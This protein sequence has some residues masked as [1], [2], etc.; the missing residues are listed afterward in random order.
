MA[1]RTFEMSGP[2]SLWSFEPPPGS[3]YRFP[4]EQGNFP[5]ESV[6]RTL[7]PSILG[8]SVLGL[9]FRDG[10]VIAADTLGSYGTLARY[11]NCERLFK[12]NDS[13]VI[14][15]SGDFADFQY[16]KGLLEQQV[17][18]EECLNDGFGFTPQS[19]HCLLTRLMYSRRDQFNPLWNTIIVAGLEDDKPY[20]GYVDF[21]GTAY[22]AP[23]T[24]TGFG[25]YIAQPIMRD[26]LE[27]NPELSAQEA[28]QLIDR[29]MSLLYYRD[30]LAFY[31]YQIAV[32]TR[33]GVIMK[34]PVEVQTNWDTAYMV[35]DY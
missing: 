18:V 1:S 20:T 2:K 23:S 31:K 16:I 13:T 29:C 3:F 7:K 12:V 30:K 26:A 27:K 14:G 4:T 10:A 24:A 8:G 34:S 11:R 28:V 5:L 33:E 15:A 6:Q 35:S 21:I 32:I 25:A 9:Q 17:I 22:E 19:L